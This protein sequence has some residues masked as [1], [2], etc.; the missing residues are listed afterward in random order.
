MILPLLAFAPPAVHA[1]VPRPPQMLDVTAYG[2][3]ADDNRDD[4]AAINAALR[5][6]RPGD[7]VI[8]PA[9]TFHLDRPVV[10]ETDG[11]TLRGAGQSQTRLVSRMTTRQA[12]DDGA[13]TVRGEKGQRFGTTARQAQQGTLATI[14]TP[15]RGQAVRPGDVLWFGAAN[16]DGFLRR[17]GSERWSREYPWVRQTMNVTALV[18]D[19]G[20]LVV[21]GFRHRL[22]LDLPSGSDVFAA[23]PVRGASLERFT[24]SQAVPGGQPTAVA[25]MY[26]NVF[27]DYNLPAVQWMWTEG[28][29]MRDVSVEM[30]GGHA[31]VIE[32]TLG[33]NMDGLDVNGAWNK[34]AGGTGYV[35]FARAYRCTLTRATV[36]NIRH[37]AF[38]WSAAYNTI[39]NSRLFVDVNFHGGFSRY[40]VVTGTS[41]TPPSSHRWAPVI[42]TPD[43]AR[44]APADGPGNRVDGYTAVFP[45]QDD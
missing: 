3:V 28:G 2:A 35:R 37:V 45:G 14:V 1:P 9:G 27:P 42:K 12:G 7:V 40:N 23:R 31:V 16:D 18:R 44:W 26:E 39:S 33:L 10:L 22:D 4:A 32:N 29:T 21:V 11:V 19:S 8:I 34:G 30:A 43:D 13:V 5:A 6:A 24:V 36:R 41:I 15:R 38:Q 20:A 25:G 17:L